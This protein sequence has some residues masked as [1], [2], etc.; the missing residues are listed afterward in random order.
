M[1]LAGDSIVPD[2][3]N[4]VPRSMMGLRILR[5]G[6][7]DQILEGVTDS[8]LADLLLERVWV[9]LDMLSPE[10]SMVS[11]AIERLRWAKPV[12]T[13][14]ERIWQFMKRAR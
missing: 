14:K 2:I 5:S 4:D 7:I 10:A 6:E 1:S 3:R 8:E 11:E 12:P 13:L 9:P